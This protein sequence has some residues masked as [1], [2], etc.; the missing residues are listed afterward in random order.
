MGISSLSTQPSAQLHGIGD[1]NTSLSKTEDPRRV[2]HCKSQSHSV[3][4]RYYSQEKTEFPFIPSTLLKPS[5]PPSIS[6]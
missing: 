3:W 1:E 4:P 5:L 6:A 2:K